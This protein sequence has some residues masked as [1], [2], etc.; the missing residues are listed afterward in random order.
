MTPQDPDNNNNP[1]KDP[2]DKKRSINDI[3]NELLEQ[4][5]DGPNDYFMALPMDESFEPTDSKKDPSKDVIEHIK[6]F[7]IK[8]KEVKTYL[9]RFVINQMEAKKALAIAICDH[10]NFVKEAIN[11]QPAGHYIKQNIL[12]IGPTGVGKT[13]LIKRIAELIGVPFIKSDATKFTETGYQGGDVEDLVRQLYK[14]ANNNI[15]LAEHGIIYLDEV[16][17]I[18]GTQ[19]A[20]HKDV[21]GRGVQS[22]LLKIMEDTDVVIRPPW[23]IQGQIKQMMGT[24]KADPDEKETINTKNILFIMSGAFNNLGDIIKKRLDGASIGFERKSNKKNTEDHDAY[25]KKLRT[26]DLVHFGLEPEFAGRLPVRVTLNQLNPTDLYEILIKS[27]G[28]I[29]EQYILSFKR[30]NIELA[31]NDEALHAIAQLAHEEHI[32]ARALPSTLEKIFRDF[33]FELPSTN[34]HYIF[35][36]KSLI[37]DPIRALNNYLKSEKKQLKIDIQLAID[38]KKTQHNQTIDS[39]KLMAQ[40]LHPNTKGKIT[41]TIDAFFYESNHVNSH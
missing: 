22:N 32:G 8:P 26:Q 6:S 14:K 17:K 16:D 11:T 21:S 40:C 29:L 39:T 1:P 19:S 24:K 15:D 33:K 7:H 35:A 36:T 20:Q 3:T 2:E 25:L 10:Y 38:E 12:M 34:V 37:N 18:T 31:F 23:D 5:K 28:S 41:E 27:E 30:F 13:Y 9:D 4:L